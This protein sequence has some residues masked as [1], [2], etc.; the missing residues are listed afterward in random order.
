M[1]YEKGDILYTDGVACLDL[2]SKLNTFNG[3]CGKKGF[4][5]FLQ[6]IPLQIIFTITTSIKP[7]IPAQDNLAVRNNHYFHFLNQ[8][9]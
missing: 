7:N 3:C 1:R 4:T 2:L 5:N 9:T 8:F 6:T